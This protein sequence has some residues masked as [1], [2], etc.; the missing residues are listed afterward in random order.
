MRKHI[1]AA[2]RSKPICVRRGKEP[3]FDLFLTRKLRLRWGE[4]GTRKSRSLARSLPASG[5]WA[6]TAPARD[7]SVLGR[8][9]DTGGVRSVR[10]SLRSPDFFTREKRR[11]G[12]FAPDN[13]RTCCSAA[14]RPELQGAHFDCDCEIGTPDGVLGSAAAFSALRA[15]TMIW[16][17]SL[18]LSL[19]A[20][21]HSGP[22]T[23]L[24]GT[25]AVQG[26]VQVLGSFTVN[27]Y[28]IVSASMRVKYSVIFN[29]AGLALR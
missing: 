12:L 10:K 11:H 25:T 6:G 21:S 27:L 23:E 20:Y 19:Q 1:P 3:T 16:M 4:G 9:R 14:G 2:G 28:S 15:P 8:R 26:L 13:L 22:W 18:L 17:A 29:V 24:K 5:T 7:D